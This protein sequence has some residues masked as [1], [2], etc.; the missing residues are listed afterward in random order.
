MNVLTTETTPQSLKLI[1][2]IYDINVKLELIDE[3]TNEITISTPP[4][5]IIGDYLHLIN[6]FNLKEGRFYNYNVKLDLG[7]GVDA[8]IYKGR[9]FCS[10][11]NINQLNNTY[12]SVNKDE[13]KVEGGNNDYIII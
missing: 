5:S 6:N 3:S 7:V 4:A 9:I 12:Y 11:Q 1:P 13:Y 2:R 10:D 8:I